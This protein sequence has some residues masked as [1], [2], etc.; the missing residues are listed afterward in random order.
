M[1][2]GGT[3][4][5]HA[6]KT[7]ELK[8]FGHLPENTSQAAQDVLVPYFA[9]IQRIKTMWVTPALNVQTTEIKSSSGGGGGGGK[10]GAGA[11]SGS[12]SSTFKYF[13]DL[14]AIVAMGPGDRLI[15]VIINNTLAFTGSIP[16][17]F[18]EVDVSLGQWGLMR[19]SWGTDRQL[20]PSLI[21]L[22]GMKFGGQRGKIRCTFSRLYFGSVGSTSVPTVELIIERC[23]DCTSL[24]FNI[25]DP[26]LLQQGIGANPI[27]IIYEIMTN[28]RYGLGITASKFDVPYITN[29]IFALAQTAIWIS[30]LIDSQQP[31]RTV[32]QDLCQYF[33]G[34]VRKVNGLIQIGYYTHASNNATGVV[35]LDFDAF[36]PPGVKFRPVGYSGT[37]NEV[38]MTSNNAANYFTKNTLRAADSASRLLTGQAR[39]A[40]IDRPYIVDPSVAKAYVEEFLRFNSN[41]LVTGS[42]DVIKEKMYAINVGQLALIQ[43]GDF[44]AQVLCRITSK[45]W[46]E[47]SSGKCS[48]EFEQE[49]G[50]YDSA[51]SPPKE[52]PDITPYVNAAQITHAKIVQLPGPLRDK[53]GIE[54][55]ILAERQSALDFGFL[56][57]VSDDDLI[58]DQMSSL[59]N[60]FSV[61]G[62]VTSASPAT[63]TSPAA[64][65]AFIVYMV[66]IDAGTIPN[67]TQAQAQAGTMLIFV[68]KE[69]MSL[70]GITALGNNQYYVTAIR[71]VYGS[72]VQA[73]TAGA[74]AWFAYRSHIRP[75]AWDPFIPGNT[76]FFKLQAYTQFNVFD[77]ASA[78]TFAYTI[79]SINAALLGPTK[80]T[81]GS[82]PTDTYVIFNWVNDPSPGVAGYEIRYGV[83][84]TNWQ[85]AKMAI[86]GVSSSHSVT[87]II[88]PGT[89]TFFV[90]DYDTFFYYSANI[91]SYTF[92]V[93]KLFTLVEINYG[94]A[95]HF[96][97]TDFG[98]FIDDSWGDG[99][100]TFI[101][102]FV[103][104]TRY[105]LVPI[106]QA[107]ASFVPPGGDGF[108][109]FDQFA[110]SPPSLCTFITS[111][112]DSLGQDT[113]IRSSIA[114]Y[115][116]LW[117]FSDSPF[118]GAE[119]LQTLPPQWDNAVI[120][121]GYIHPSRYSVVPLSTRLAS[122]VPL[123][124]DGFET[125]DKFVL[126]PVLT[127]DV[128]FTQ[129]LLEFGP[130][131]MTLTTQFNNGT[132]GTG[133]VIPSSGISYSSDNIHFVTAPVTGGAGTINATAIAR[134][135]NYSAHLDNSDNP[136]TI[137]SMTVDS[138][139]APDNYWTPINGQTRTSRDN[140]T[141]TDW[142]ETDSSFTPDRY[143]QYK[144]EWSPYGSIWPVGISS[145]WFLLDSDT[146]NQRAVA[147]VV[148]IG[149]TTFTFAP[150]FRLQLPTVHVTL[151]SPGAGFPIITAQSL[152]AFTVKVFNQAGADVGGIINWIAEG[153]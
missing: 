33:D 47:D 49:R 143:N 17:V 119:F 127:T 121:N 32:I 35:S 55:F 85:Q 36:L 66:G 141:F 54:L 150:P 48:I 7:P 136:G 64:S 117:G 38:L 58:F 6:E 116:Y 2:L 68:D 43:A 72:T 21:N 86:R 90:T 67:L 15:G 63:G 103:H 77:L 110:V 147:R 45:T 104:P 71:G 57:W 8:D 41:P 145:V 95:Q 144:V 99:N 126:D 28:V 59:G 56:A 1:S 9:G 83:V 149:G 10:G 76:Y 105:V 80:L 29:R 51:Y 139:L 92:T 52:Y 14:V 13:A 130:V 101:N 129:D 37:I 87:L 106:D 30:P 69:I 107:L 74:Q 75:L 93:K 46:G 4:A 11:S 122:Y 24:G 125:F 114:V 25:G 131:N 123:S 42:G 137:A 31:F 5:I 20:A 60:Y 132:D 18:D 27:A 19:L 3:P 96:V 118:S 108:E 98:A 100:S 91:L 70:Q 62:T 94:E 151:V 61:M 73:H 109:T 53:T 50:T 120:T 81:V 102:C 115:E 152:T 23:P 133:N 97:D 44:G 140:I 124:G 146:T 34:F 82:D 148:S 40:Q 135:V 39:N 128:L 79:G 112:I 78:S 138:L 26:N 153:V 84:G 134:Y 16:R 142:Q 113:N 88:P 12:S 89:W 65:F 22:N 111:V